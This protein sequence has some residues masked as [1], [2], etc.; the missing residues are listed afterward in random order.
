LRKTRIRDR[1]NYAPLFH[2]L[3]NWRCL[4]SAPNF[5]PSSNFAKTILERF[6]HAAGAGT[7][8]R[9]ISK[10]GRRAAELA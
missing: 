1:V 7:R 4:S 6:P 3:A 10:D 2:R 9:L 5:T 8:S